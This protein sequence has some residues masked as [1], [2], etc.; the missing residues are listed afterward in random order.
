MLARGLAR[1]IVLAA[2]PVALVI[3]CAQIEGLTGF[4]KVDGLVGTDSGSTPTPT[5]DPVPVPSG[6]VG[7]DAL[8]GGSSDGRAPDDGSPGGVDGSGPPSDPNANLALTAV[9][10]ATSTLP[11]YPAAQVN[12]G[13]LSTSWYAA[14]GSCTA[15]QGTTTYGCGPGFGGAQPTAIALQW[16]SPQTIGHVRLYGNRDAP[17]GFNVLTGTIQLFDGNGHVVQSVDVAT[18]AMGDFETTFQPVSG[19]IVVQEALITA[20]SDEPG[21]AELQVFAK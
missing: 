13:N 21:V 11:N 3:G 8:D 12:D 17:T 6:P 4:E 10:V 16:A 5:P 15:T 2:A 18:G 1:T 7:P 19:V 20:E 9:A 14:K